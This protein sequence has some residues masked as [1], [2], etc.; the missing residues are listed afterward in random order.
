M[1]N[2]V[3]R[4]RLHHQLSPNQINWEEP[5]F[6]GEAWRDLIFKLRDNRGNKLTPEVDRM[7]D[8]PVTQGIWVHEDGTIEARDH[9]S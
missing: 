6:D 8:T 7:V 3:N 9:N 4:Q 2:S 5:T 1:G